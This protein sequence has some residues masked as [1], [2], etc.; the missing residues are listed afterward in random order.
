MNPPI[1]SAARTSPATAV[2]NESKEPG[3][4]PGSTA[5]VGGSRT[6]PLLE[7]KLHVQKLLKGEVQIQLEFPQPAELAAKDARFTYVKDKQGLNTF[8]ERCQQMAGL[9]SLKI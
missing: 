6:A 8:D 4:D 3:A 9:L 7:G 5:S 2:P 1:E